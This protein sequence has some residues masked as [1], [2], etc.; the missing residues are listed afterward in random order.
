[1]KNAINRAL[2]AKKNYMKNICLFLMLLGTCAHAWSAETQVAQFAS[3]T[4]IRTQTYTEWTSSDGMWYLSMGGNN[5]GAGFNSN[6]WTT[7]GNAYGTSANTS[8]HGFYIRSVNKLDNICKITFWYDFCTT[9]SECDKAKI[10]LG[11]STDG[12]SWS[13]I[14]ITNGDA[15]GTNVKPSKWDGDA[16]SSYNTTT[17]TFEFSK[18]A[19]AYY[20]IIISRNG[21]MTTDKGF[22]FDDATVTFYSGCCEELDKPTG[23]TVTQNVDGTHGKTRFGWNAV[24]NA[25]GYVVSITKNGTTTNTY[26]RTV[27]QLYLKG[28]LPAGNY[29]W[30]VYAKGNGDPYCEENPAQDGTSFCIGA[31]LTAVTPSNLSATP[32]STTSARISWDAVSG[33]EYYEV[34]V[35]ED[36]KVATVASDI[37]EGTT[38]DVTGLTANK[39]YRFYWKAVNICDDA[40]NS[41][42]NSAN[43]F[44]IVAHTVDFDL[45]GKGSGKPSDQIIL[46]GGKATKPSNPTPPSGWSFGGW[47]KEAGC[48]NA[49][50][51]GSDVVNAD[52]TLYAKWVE[53]IYYQ[54]DVATT[55][56]V[57]IIATP[58]GSSAVSEGNYANVEAG[59]TVTVNYSN[60][61]TASGYSWYGW[62]VYKTGDT[63]TKVSLSSSTANNATFTMPDYPVTVSAKLFG[64][65]RAFCEPPLDATLVQQDGNTST[66]LYVTSAAEQKVKAVR[67]LTLTVTGASGTQNVTLSGTDLLF[68][69]KDGT[70]ITGS[71][72]Q[73]DGTGDLAATEIVVAYAPS[74]YVDENFATPSITVTCD[75]NTKTFNNLVTARCLPTTFVIAAKQNGHWY[76]LPAT[77]DAANTY[78]PIPLMVNSESDPTSATIARQNSVEY[79][80]VELSTPGAGARFSSRVI[81]TEPSTYYGNL[82][83]GANTGEGSNTNI[84]NWSET[85]TSTLYEWR[86]DEADGGTPLK[87]YNL[88]NATNNNHTLALNKN[89]GILT[90]GMYKAASAQK[91][92][93]LLP[94]TFVEFCDINIRDWLTNGFIFQ[95]ERSET[96]SA[97]TIEYG[98]TS[99]TASSITD[100]NSGAKGRHLYK[101]IF[102]TA[103]TGTAAACK[104]AKITMTVADDTKYTLVNIPIIVA[105]NVT[106]TAE[107][108]AT[109]GTTDCE[110]CDVVIRDKATLTTAGGGSTT[111]DKVNDM[112][113]YPGATLSIQGKEFT[114]NSLNLRGGRL[115]Y[116]DTE[117]NQAHLYMGKKLTK[118]ATIINYEMRVGVDQHYGFALPYAANVDDIHYANTS[119]HGTAGTH[120]Q[121][122]SFNGASRA[123]GSTGDACWDRVTSGTLAAGTGYL[124]QAKRPSGQPY[125]DVIIPMSISQ[126]NFSIDANGDKRE[127]VGISVA[128]HS[129]TYDNDKGWNFIGNPYTARFDGKTSG[130]DTDDANLSGAITVGKL[131]EQK[132]GGNWTGHYEW[133]ETSLAYVT[134]PEDDYSDYKQKRPKAVKFEPFRNFFVQVN[135]N[136]TVTFYR[137]KLTTTALPGY[138]R[139]LAEEQLPDV[140]LTLWLNHGGASDNADL[141][142]SKDASADVLIGDEDFS[143]WTDGTSLK[144]YS[145]MS[146]NRLG[147]NSLPHASAVGLPLG[148]IAREGGT[149]S[150]ELDEEFVATNVQAV[151]LKDK[152]ENVEAYNLL[153]DAYE[154]ELASAEQNDERFELTVVMKEKGVSSDLTEE[155]A[156][157]DIYVVSAE[158]GFIVQ[159]VEVG[160]KVWVFDMTGKLIDS[161]VSKAESSLRFTV[162]TG[163]YNIR[164]TQNGEGVT[165]RA[166]VR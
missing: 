25:S 34:E 90:W 101:V 56:G 148:Y 52:Q 88:Y 134:M 9:A 71:V 7:I 77:M 103:L 19:S 23:L 45:N 125:A 14:P 5:K 57:I 58:S 139:Q 95:T 17:W 78:A 114:V 79:A 44:S 132:E 81:Q 2:A 105:S 74:A 157:S 43:T 38:W 144:F 29:T 55:A 3:G 22:R 83:A 64:D 124:L 28:D 104:Q 133:S 87:D 85:S 166:V 67:L 142:L 75:G 161:R 33:A 151:Y 24:T 59:T 98:A 68:Y 127:S 115:S 6:N 65:L 119:S 113:I 146:G 69:K 159:G 10:Y 8:H 46:H 117:I 89:A 112:Y 96:V 102:P 120:F 40:Y 35:K 48:T 86:M 143:K 110:F 150:I 160:A 39:T 135:A 137:N 37:I 62:D 138:R 128:A 91:T 122:L 140:E 60:V 21:S 20:A 61:E 126:E 63:G 76:A 136:G 92:I 129:S 31:D 106:I 163:I 13:A 109:I 51:F 152:V 18:I 97:V 16:G 123:G 80:L 164:V 12:S 36:G 30:S 42:V 99:Q 82:R 53:R 54:L 84:R 32:L 118:K 154:F 47:Y 147:L 165:K 145:V 93:R 94:A 11:Y 15:Q 130:E 107:P 49:W 100:L 26:E 131:E 108:F 73:T 27:D 1:M 70:Q 116:E 153:L 155:T 50:N 111:V 72:L 141:T 156:L 41:A 149:Y 4:V 121:I 158:N 66:P 162:P